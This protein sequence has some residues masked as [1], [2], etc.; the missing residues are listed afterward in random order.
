MPSTNGRGPEWAI[1]Y[2]RVSGDDQVKGYSLDQQAGA[3]REWVAQ[4]GYEL[5]EEIRDEGW[6]VPA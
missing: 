1:V 4:E 6:S 3:L 2:A 5:M